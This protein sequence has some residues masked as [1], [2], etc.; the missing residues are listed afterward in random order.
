MSEF[1]EKRVAESQ[2]RASLRKANPNRQYGSTNGNSVSGFQYKASA[3]VDKFAKYIEEQ[4]LYEPNTGHGCRVQ[5]H[6][7]EACYLKFNAV[8]ERFMLEERENIKLVKEA[9]K[10]N[11]VEEE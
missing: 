9:L 8:I 4:M 6:H 7:V 11:K 5:R 1:Q 10:Q 2:A 3:I